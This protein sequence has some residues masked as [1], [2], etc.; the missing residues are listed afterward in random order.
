[1][2][3]AFDQFDAPAGRPRITVTPRQDYSGAISS[4]ESG[5]RYD[6]VGPETGKGR[7]LGKYQV[8]DFN[9]GPWTQ[10]VFGRALSPQEFLASPQAQDAVFQHKFGQ[11]AQKYGPEGAARAWFAGER[12]MNDPTRRDVLGTTVAD[13]SRK[14]TSAMGR[15][16][17][18]DQA[19]SFATTA[20]APT[21]PPPPAPAKAQQRANPFDQ[22]DG[23]APASEVIP[24]NERA[25][26]KELSDIT[27]GFGDVG[28]GRA[29]A[30]GVLSGVSANFRDE[31]YGASKASGLPEW[32]GG[33]RAPIGAARLA[34][35]G[36]TG[37]PGSAT[38]AYEAGK[39]EIR[40]VQK[41]AQEQYP[42]TTLAG[43]I[44][45]AV[46]LPVGGVMNAAT[47][48]GRIGRSA[49]VGAAYGGAAG[50]GEGDG[51]S[52]RA[53][54]AAGGAALGG[55][56]GGVA[57][58]VL[59]GAIRGGA[60]L[61]RPAASMVRGLVNPEAEAA[62]RVLTGISR[63]VKSGDA[64]MDAAEFAAARAAG[65][66]AAVVDLGGNTTR[67]L[68]RS[69]ANTS[70]EGRAALERLTNDR[71]E[72]QGSRVVDFVTTLVRTP[73]NAGKTRE[74]LEQAARTARKPFYD[75][76]YRDGAGGIVTPEISQIAGAPI[77]KAAMNEALVSVQ[78][79]TA[80]GR[81]LNV[82]SPSGKPTL[83]FWDQVKRSL[84]S[85]ISVLRR[86]G[87]KEATADAETIKNTLVNVLDR[88]VPS[89]GVARGVAASFFKADSALEAGEKFV[90]QNFA[91][92]EVRR[93]LSKMT[94][95]ERDLFAEGFVSRMVEMI[96]KTGDRR[97]VL[98]TIA[99]SKAARE[100]IELAIG[101]NRAKELEVFLR[102]ESIMDQMRGA[103][104]N[105]TTARQLIEAGLA[106]GAYG[107]VTGDFSVGNVATGAGAFAAAR[108]GAKFAGQRIDQNVARRVA[109]MLASHDPKVLQKG[110]R[111]VANN[112]S[113][114][115]A[116]RRADDYA[117]RIGGFQSG[118]A[119][120]LQAPSVSRA[121][122]D[123][124]SVPR[125]P[126]Q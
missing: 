59:E 96:D 57:A 55:A 121:E 72:G 84:D 106:G 39:G 42:G 107:A 18:Q 53:T 9:V 20:E 99:N 88:E 73:A 85:K 33:F 48:P 118:G 35:E 82:L 117:A 80:S 77:M 66:P 15:G 111:L 23:A 113:L 79:K 126:G 26:N 51:F 100:K 81:A 78:N 112:A 47:L 24:D 62:R 31:V 5:G 41:A 49:A 7:A 123:K 60:A 122:E 105:S 119:P 19:M 16:G 58:P 124:P 10:E 1:M 67:A 3:N 29:L 95:E 21:F 54:R 69:A 93:A 87:D 108:A 17:G 13:Y 46:A 91:T 104:G 14:F 120:L 6:L 12:G 52:D 36:I 32:M 90:T 75:R 110:L 83:E 4:I 65:Q 40:A 45:G 8:M 63:D 11:Y 43:N 98:N 56:I 114:M 109:D 27:S 70:P 76:A 97:N 71:F 103:L 116:V 61:A 2:A 86:Q 30:E 38:Q 28:Q 74:A 94:P 89:Y 92:H 102:R 25:A 22:F 50:A 101:A 37:Q 68:A 125:P 34:Y 64:G 44:A 115:K